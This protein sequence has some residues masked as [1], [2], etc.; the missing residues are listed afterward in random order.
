MEHQKPELLIILSQINPFKC[1]VS[2][3]AKAL[4]HLCPKSPP[5]RSPWKEFKAQENVPPGD[6]SSD[7]PCPK[8]KHLPPRGPPAPSCKHPLP[9][10]Q[11]LPR[12]GRRT[13]IRIL[14]L[15][16]L[17]NEGKERPTQ[18]QPQRPPLCG[19]LRETP[20]R[21]RRRKRTL[22]RRRDPDPEHLCRAVPHARPP[23]AYLAA[24]AL[25]GSRG[26]ISLSRGEPGGTA[27]RLGVL[28]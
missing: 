16:P 19:L 4:S 17:D 21:S 27:P 15:K 23:P 26:L 9:P 3:R 6:S 22:G 5:R 12:R 8:A 14:N 25:A 7:P 18:G 2:G 13:A 24:R 10:G 1:F 11:R 20:L 28:C